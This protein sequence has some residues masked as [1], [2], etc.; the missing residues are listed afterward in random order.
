MYRA[1]QTVNTSFPTLNMSYTENRV[2]ELEV[3][4]LHCIRHPKKEKATARVRESVR[5][6]VRNSECVYMH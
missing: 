4:C 1:Q 6:M 2:S 5:G 3:Q